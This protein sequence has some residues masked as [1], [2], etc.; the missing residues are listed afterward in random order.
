MIPYIEM[1]YR[2]IP[3]IEMRYRIY[4]ESEHIPC[5]GQGLDSGK[6]TCLSGYMA[7]FA[8]QPGACV[9]SCVLACRWNLIVARTS[10]YVY[11]YPYTLYPTP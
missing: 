10:P 8:T 5:R 3:Y 1:R 9:R 2:M 11:I 6:G 7:T 4:I